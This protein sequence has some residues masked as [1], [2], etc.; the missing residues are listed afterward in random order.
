MQL[1]LHWLFA[2]HRTLELVMTSPWT[3]LQICSVLVILIYCCICSFCRTSDFV[4]HINCLSTS[5]ITLSIWLTCLL[6][7][8]GCIHL[9]F[10][11][12]IWWT[13]LL[14]VCKQQRSLKLFYQGFSLI[15]YILVL[16]STC[17]HHFHWLLLLLFCFQ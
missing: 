12:Y 16:N 15:E 14:L 2:D 4:S 13:C 11:V 3:I 5:S 1:E 17:R 10:L 9:A 6:L 7:V 8:L